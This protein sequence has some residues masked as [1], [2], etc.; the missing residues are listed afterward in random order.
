MSAPRIVALVV[1]HQRKAQL[2]RT[3]TRLLAEPLDHVVVVDNASRDG[4]AEWLRG[5]DEPRL[6]LLRRDTNGGGAAGF[7]AG[8]RAIAAR[9]DPDWCV[10]MDDDARP[11]P[12]AITRFRAALRQG[13]GARWEAL[14]A[15]VRTPDGTICEMNRPA[16]NP[17]WHLPS[18]LRLACGTGRAGFHL[19]DAAYAGQGERRIDTASFVGLFLSRAA[20][21]RAGF[22]DG[23]LF[24]Y[25]D[26]VLYT[27]RLGQAGGR[28]GFAPWLRFEHDCATFRPGQ[29]RLHHPLWKA[30]YAYRNG[31]LAYR[32]AAGPVLFWPVLPL[33]LARW[34]MHMRG[35][36]AAQRSNR[37]LLWLA[38]GDALCGRLQR[39]HRQVRARARLLARRAG[40][41]PAPQAQPSSASAASSPGAC[42]TLSR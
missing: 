19:P 42:A 20:I 1:T 21:R 6:W 31:I 16:R 3:V 26:D 34:L 28:I 25:G 8:L 15:A 5:L 30:Y 11:D 37:G 23:A 27:L 13:L 32:A 36:G 35:S 40:G 10:L 39:P 18:L 9:L 2:Q 22:P 33:A 29:G 4:S 17:F 14:A 38:L 24:L 41:L 7:E 12:G